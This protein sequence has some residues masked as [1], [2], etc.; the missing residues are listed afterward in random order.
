MMGSERYGADAWKSSHWE[1]LL[2]RALS[3]VVDSTKKSN[4]ADAT[5][6]ASIDALAETGSPQAQGAMSRLGWI[7]E[8]SC[9]TNSTLAAVSVPTIKL[10]HRSGS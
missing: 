4:F 9:S 10:A 2:A 6:V 1:V 8:N 5:I 7:P 3:E